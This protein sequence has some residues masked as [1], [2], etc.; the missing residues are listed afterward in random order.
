MTEAN[1]Y[2]L[3]NRAE[4]A[5]W[6]RRGQMHGMARGGTR[7]HPLVRA[8]P[9]AQ[10]AVYGGRAMLRLLGAFDLVAFA[11]RRNQVRG[12]MV[13]AIGERDHVIEREV[14]ECDGIVAQGAEPPAMLIAESFEDDGEVHRPHRAVDAAPARA[15][16]ETQGATPHDVD[17]PLIVGGGPGHFDG[18]SGDAR[19]R[20][21]PGRGVRS[22]GDAR[23]RA[24]NPRGRGEGAGGAWWGRE[25]EA[26]GAFPWRNGVGAKRARRGGH[27]GRSEGRRLGER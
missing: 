19:A 7:R 24:G 6:Q 15:A 8:G 5:R 2:P 4:L 9:F 25:G 23:I 11:V 14:V 22:N 1:A 12:L 18:W 16:V 10:P 13:A 3:W 27:G 21:C 26:A 17:H 20:W